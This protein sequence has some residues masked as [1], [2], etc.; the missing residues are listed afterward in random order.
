MVGSLSDSVKAINAKKP[1]IETVS[2][3]PTL[4]KL[5]EAWK[6]EPILSVD[7]QVGINR[8]VPLVD[9]HYLS[10]DD[11]GWYK[12]LLIILSIDGILLAIA[13]GRFILVG[14]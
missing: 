9:E 2:E 14:I 13:L 10:P 6:D 11:N 8:L 7:N 5:K 4:K 12:W 1:P 3:E